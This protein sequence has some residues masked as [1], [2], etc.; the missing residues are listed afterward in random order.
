MWTSSLPEWQASHGAVYMQCMLANGP[1]RSST[2]HVLSNA[3][4]LA[5]PAAA[6]LVSGL[7]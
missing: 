5:M 4:Q 6:L 7:C 3:D 2:K 1:K